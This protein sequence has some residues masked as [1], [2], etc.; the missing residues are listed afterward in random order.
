MINFLTENS[1]YKVYSIYENVYL[2]SKKDSMNLDDFET[3]DKLI[4]NHY[5]DPNDAIILNS[6]KHIIISGCGLSIYYIDDG[7]EK[8]ILA[9][10]DNITWT[11]GLFQDESDHQLLEVRFVALNQVDQLRV[12]KMNIHSFEIIEL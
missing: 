1:E 4:T 10:P 2:K 6:G 11:N 12:F 5:G 9:E 8:H 7:F 3:T